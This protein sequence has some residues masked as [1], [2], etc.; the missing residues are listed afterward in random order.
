MFSVFNVSDRIVVITGGG[1]GIGAWLAEGFV[2]EGAKVYLAGR[3]ESSLTQTT[4]KLNAIR[5]DS[6]KYCVTDI[7]QKN[8]LDNLVDFIKQ[9]E[10]RID[11][12]INN[13]GAA[14]WD[15]PGPDTDATVGLDSKN[16]FPV[17][18]SEDPSQWDQQYRV[19]TW[20]PYTLTLILLPLLAEA[21]G[22]SCSSAFNLN[23]AY[24]GANAGL[25]HISKILGAR[26]Y[27]HGVRVNVV[28]PGSFPTDSNLP[29]NPYAMSHSS[30][31]KRIP[32]GRSGTPTDITST[33]IFFASAASAYITGQWIDVDGGR[34][35]VANGT[36]KIAP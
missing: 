2:K 12:L 35:L 8:D 26:L 31:D 13:G 34:M 11:V 5:P 19:F 23:A 36:N 1:S 14:A 22:W 4:D 30:N 18:K 29:D 9:H 28:S 25:E 16:P 15:L 21:A 33:V 10:T 32:L 27:P 6:A 7:T 17:I 3:R 24:S 20:A